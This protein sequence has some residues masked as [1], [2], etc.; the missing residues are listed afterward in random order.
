MKSSKVQSQ[1]LAQ[2]VLNKILVKSPKGVKMPKG[3]T[4]LKKSWWQ[5]DRGAK[6]SK[7]AAG[8]K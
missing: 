7:S 1:L 5:H 8:S 3:T 4:K 2:L 6:P